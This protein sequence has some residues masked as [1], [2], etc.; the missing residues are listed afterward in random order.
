VSDNVERRFET[1]MYVCIY[2]CIFFINEACSITYVILHAVVIYITLY[3]LSI[4]FCLSFLMICVLLFVCLSYLSLCC[5]RSKSID[6]IKSLY[7]FRYL[8]IS[9]SLLS[10]KFIGLFIRCFSRSLCALV[11]VQL[12][13]MW[14]IV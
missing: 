5:N 2:V 3:T 9:Y 11:F 7:K 1:D 8:V 4:I 12:K 13:R 6:S 10:C 14:S